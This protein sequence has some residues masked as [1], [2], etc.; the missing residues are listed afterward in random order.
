VCSALH[1]RDVYRTLLACF[2]RRSSMADTVAV[3]TLL[4][5]LVAALLCVSGCDRLKGSRR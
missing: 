1:E 4:I 2:D 3:F 5:L